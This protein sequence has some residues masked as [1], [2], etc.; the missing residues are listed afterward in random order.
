MP[1]RGS[2]NEG[3]AVQKILEDALWYWRRRN[4]EETYNAVDQLRSVLKPYVEEQIKH[5]SER[6]GLDN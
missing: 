4:L 5:K 3:A 1:D 6:H 2:F